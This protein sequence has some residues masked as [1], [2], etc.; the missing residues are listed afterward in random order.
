M[1]QVSVII[2]TFNRAQTLTTAI[3]SVLHQ[4]FQD[5]ELIIVDDGSTDDTT[6]VLQPYES[7]II[8]YFQQ[9]GGVS[10]ARNAGIE[11]ATGEF[12][13]FLDSDDLWL[14]KKLE[15]Q[16]AFFERD[17]QAV[18]CYTDEI[19]IRNGVRVNPQKK[20]RKYHGWIFQHSLP[21][22]IVSPSSICLS[23]SI[24]SD[25]GQFDVTLPACEDYDFWLRLSIRYPVHFIP[26]PLIIKRG[27]HADQLS[28]RTPIMDRY[29]II[30][31]EKLLLLEKLSPQQ[32][33]SV[34][35]ELIRKCLII[36][37]GAY[38]RHKLIQAKYYQSKIERYQQELLSWT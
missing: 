17:S 36:R 8:Y 29:R 3:Q 19:W 1:P 30:A 6:R 23:R 9:N 35:K 24:I 12:I 26:V 20:H 31:L 16:I 15:H 21:L 14:N 38:K 22:C 34:L 7:S 2:P 11:L 18:A 27:G 37:S 4:S 13:A 28:R 5:F 33:Q 25:A 10:S 32:R